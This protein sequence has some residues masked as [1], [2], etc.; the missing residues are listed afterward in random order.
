[1]RTEKQILMELRRRMKF[2]FYEGTKTSQYSSMN[3]NFIKGLLYA[4]GYKVNIIN[5]NPYIIINVLMKRKIDTS[6][7]IE[8]TRIKKMMRRKKTKPRRQGWLWET[9]E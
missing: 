6:N 7:R 9:T 1:M 3:I 2:R 8:K 5:S 4:L